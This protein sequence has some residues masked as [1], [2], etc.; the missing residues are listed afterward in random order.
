MTL[1]FKLIFFVVF[2]IHTTFANSEWMQVTE[3][4]EINFFVELGSVRLIDDGIK[5]VWVLKNFKDPKKNLGSHQLK[6][7]MDCD[8]DEMRI[9][10]RYTYSGK[11]LSGLP[12]K[13]Y[14]KTE[15]WRSVKTDTNLMAVHNLI[16]KKK[17]K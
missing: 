12:I 10:S 16:C 13:D 2:L 5:S 9:S 11:F 17:V 4:A 6:L 14:F 1:S 8:Q 7:E 15:E 3:N